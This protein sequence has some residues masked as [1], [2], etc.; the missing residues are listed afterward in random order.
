MSKRYPPCHLS[1]GEWGECSSSLK[2]V[3]LLRRALGAYSARMASASGPSSEPPQQQGIS[4]HALS[5]AFAR[6]LT[7]QAASSPGAAPTNQEESQE[8]R[9]SPET[10]SDG[11]AAEGG[12]G[13]EVCAAPPDDAESLGPIIAQEDPCPVCPRT[14]LEA[15]LFVGNQHNEPLSSTQAA[16]LMRGVQPDDIPG[17]VDELNRRYASSNAPY[18]IVSQGSGYRMV[19]RRTF[20]P[21]RNRLYGRVREARLSQAAVDVLAIVA[22]RQP[23]TAEQIS[24]LRGKPS[25]SVL[26]QLVRRQLLRIERPEGRRQP[27]RYYTTGRFLELFGLKGPEDLP[28]AE[29]IDTH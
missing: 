21:L 22:Y 14:I 17:L 10:I 27:V 18:Q 6:A 28:Q 8:R 29:D 5:E 11:P 25:A 26:S 3:L 24:Q 1:L 20:F 16:A 15:M 13:P 7:R 4:F 2:G 9:A 12:G 19:L 23:L